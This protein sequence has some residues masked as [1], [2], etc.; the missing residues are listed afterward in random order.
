MPPDQGTGVSLKFPL[1]FCLFS[2]FY[3]PPPLMSIIQRCNLLEGHCIM[4]GH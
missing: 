4:A 1:L 3:A 2:S